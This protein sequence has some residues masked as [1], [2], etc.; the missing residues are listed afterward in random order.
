MSLLVPEAYGGSGCSLE[1]VSQIAQIL[2]SSCLNTGVIWSMHCQQVALLVQHLHGSYRQQLLFRLA[3]EQTYIASITTEQN[4]NENIFKSV[5]PLQKTDQGW[6]LQ[7]T[8][9]IVT[10]GQHGDLFLI[11]MG[12]ITDYSDQDVVVAIVDRNNAKIDYTSAW[13]SMGMRGTGSIGMEIEAQLEEAHILK[14]NNG[15]KEIALQTIVPV[16]HIALSSSW[17]GAAK[18]VFEKLTSVIR[19]PANRSKFNMNSDLL[20]EKL[21]KIR[22]KLDTVDH[23]LKEM[24]RQYDRIRSDDPVNLQTNTFSIQINNLKIL[25]SEMLYDAVDEMVNLAGVGYGYTKNETIPLERTLR[26]LKS[27]RLMYRNDLLLTT[28]GKLSLFEKNWF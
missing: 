8:A 2:S 4:K 14:S 17:L 23:Y 5:S 16:G 13:N 9:P 21:G 26:D 19:R 1:T 10:G 27:A 22:I 12:G 7:R 3:S 11:Y 18:G 6:L 15:F 20:F 24:I 28:N 25:A